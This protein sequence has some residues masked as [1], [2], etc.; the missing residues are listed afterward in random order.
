MPLTHPFNTHTQTYISGNWKQIWKRCIHSHVY[1]MIAKR[2]KQPKTPTE[3]WM[4][5]EKVICTYSRVLALQKE[6]LSHGFHPTTWMKLKDSMLSKMK[7]KVM[8]DSATPGTVAH[9]VPVSMEFPRQEYWSELSYHSPGDLPDPGRFFTVWAK[10]RPA[11][12][13]L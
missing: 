10:T 5:R 1:C 4:D 6:I 9:Q 8:S 11:W 12:F 7:V 2:W 3:R 13:H